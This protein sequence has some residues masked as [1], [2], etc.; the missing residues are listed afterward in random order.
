MADTYQLDI[1]TPDGLVFSE[2]IEHLRAPGSEGSFGV[3]VGHTPF[4]TPLAVGQ[5][6]VTQG[7]KVRLLATSGGF[8]E[9]NPDRT[10]ILAETA[11]FA[12]DIDVERAEAARQRAEERIKAGP[13][14]TDLDRAES[15]LIRAVNRIKIAR[16]AH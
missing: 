16:Q 12:K 1:V 7:G 15:A 6:D 11:E 3:L 9:V 5:V 2:P 8:I 10:V 4:M 13:P 14:D